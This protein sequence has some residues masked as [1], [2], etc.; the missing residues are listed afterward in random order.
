MIIQKKC[1]TTNT[2]QGHDHLSM[3]AVFLEGSETKVSGPFCAP[4]IN[5]QNV[6]QKAVNFV[7]RR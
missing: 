2:W 3:T 6:R 1:Y 5:S 7:Y 4:N